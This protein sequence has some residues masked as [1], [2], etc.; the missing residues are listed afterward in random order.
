MA[1]QDRCGSASKRKAP[2]LP[3]WS[4][5]VNLVARSQRRFT[6]L[7]VVRFF[8]AVRCCSGSFKRQSAKAGWGVEGQ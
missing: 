1:L 8:D 4:R 2:A 6:G 7:F 5:P 3:T